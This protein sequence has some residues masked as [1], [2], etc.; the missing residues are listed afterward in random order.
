[1]SAYIF[2]SVEV[3]DPVR[4]EEYRKTVLRTIE[5]Y[6]GRFLVRGG[7]ME[8]LEGSWPPRRIVIVEF[9]SVEKARA[10]W[11]SSEYAAPKALRQAT[12][13]TEMILVEG[14]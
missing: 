5:A 10:W 7:K 3:L 14:V 4:Y 2:V 8:V 1:M 9:P 13:H 11:N 12:S 6:G